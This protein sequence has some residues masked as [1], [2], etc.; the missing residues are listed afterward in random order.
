MTGGSLF[1]AAMALVMPQPVQ[2][3]DCAT[4]FAGPGGKA[5]ATRFFDAPPQRTRETIE[6]AMQ[7]IGVL[8]IE[9]TDAV[10]RGE[11][12]DVRVKVLKLPSGDE[13]VFAH[14]QATQR[15]GRPG[16]LVR[17]ETRRRGGKPGDPKH[18]WSSAVLD[19]TAFLLD[20]L[21]KEAPAP[22]AHSPA[23]GGMELQRDVVI[24]AGTLVPLI[25]RRFVFSND[26][27]VNQKL[28]FEVASDV[29]IGSDVVFR[30]GALTVARVKM[31]KDGGWGG[32][33]G[34]EKA[35]VEFEFASAAG[36][37]R[38]PVH[39]VFNLAGRG[40]MKRLMSSLLFRGDFAEAALCAGTRFDV[41]VDG[42][43]RT[44]IG[45]Q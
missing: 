3:P 35:R 23:A 45:D 1:A 8:L 38:I 13:A 30:R 22:M 19:G 15:D 43:Q 7:A 10:V 12:V 11:R 44:R 18:T 33:W 17:V 36:G 41:A 42:E 5:I 29:S 34:T 9:S 37:G 14:L 31:V 25:L 6:D 20:L 39:A 28:A 4:E 27:R 16:T 26:L 32:G 21:A 24:P 40:A 2:R